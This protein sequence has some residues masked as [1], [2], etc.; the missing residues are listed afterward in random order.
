VSFSV[1]RHVLPTAPLDC[2]G[3]VAASVR[4][5]GQETEYDLCRMLVARLVV[6][7]DAAASVKET[8][9]ALREARHGDGPVLADAG[10][11]KGL[12]QVLPAEF[13]SL[14]DLDIQAQG[15]EREAVVELVD[16]DVPDE[17]F[18]QFWTH[19][20]DSLPCS[21]TERVGRLRREVMAT[22]DFY[23][24]R[25]WHSTGMYSEVM[26]PAGVDNDLV[27]PLPAPVGIARRLIF[28]RSPGQAFT[29]GERAAAI[30]LQPH[31]SEALRLHARLMAARPLTA[32]QL[33]LLQLV[34][35]GH[36]NNAIARRLC[37]S[38]GTVRK[39]LENAFTRL[40]VSS[41]TAAVAHTFPDTTWI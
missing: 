36:D 17:P 35:A 11:V 1:R 24:D 13:A 9:G 41:R 25:Q 27:I 21:Y 14:N 39:H 16:H 19:F 6:V 34:A 5:S 28:F 3:S 20:W 29:D 30:L 15:D 7:V 37:L 38:R 8:V 22:G 2:V 40:G 33:E 4:H 23:S 18:A 31:I 32:R 26:R 10:V 12:L